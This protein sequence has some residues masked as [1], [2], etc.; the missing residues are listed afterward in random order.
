MSHRGACRQNTAQTFTTTNICDWCGLHGHSLQQ[1]SNWYSNW[2]SWQA[3][4]EGEALGYPWDP[5]SLW[6]KTRPEEKEPKTTERLKERSGQRWRWQKR[7]GYRV[8]ASERITA[9]KHTSWPV[10]DLKTEK[11]SKSTTTTEEHVGRV[12]QLQ[13]QISCIPDKDF[14]DFRQCWQTLSYIPLSDPWGR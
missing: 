10:K 12:L 11:Q 6:P 2:S 14:R 4:S 1:G 9:R 3:T 8:I 7:L 13:L 5:S